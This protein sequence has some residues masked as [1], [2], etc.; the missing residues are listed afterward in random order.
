MSQFFEDKGVEELLGKGVE[1]SWINDDKIDRV[2]DDLFEF[3]LNQI[4]VEIVLS[5]IKKFAI[6]TKYY[7]WEATSFHLEGE[8]HKNKE[9]EEEIIK[10]RPIIITKGSSLY[11]RPDLK[12]CVLDLITSSDGD[13]PLFMKAGD[14]NESDK[15][16]FGRILGELTKPLDLESILVCDIAL[17]SQENLQLIQN[18]KWITRVPMTI[19]KAQLLVQTVEIEEIDEKERKRRK[20][21]NWEG[22]KWKEEIVNYGGIEQLWLV[23]ESEKRQKSDLEKL[24]KKLEKE[25]VKVEKYLKELKREELENTAQARYKLKGINKTLKL[26]K[27]EEVALIEGESKEKK[28]IN[29]IPV[30]MQEKGEEI[31]RG[32][33][34]AGRFILATNLGAENRLKPEEILPAYKNQQFGERGFIFLKYPWFFADSFFLKNSQKNWNDVVFNVSWFIGL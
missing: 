33:K 11:H 16:V 13:L 23:L 31:A 30:V 21:L 18:L 20:D 3:D 28:L 22:Y 14:G 5:V 32:K 4:F 17:Y 7:H 19:K 26:F 1:S 12:Q 15:A 8:Y 27:I 29:K 2:I 10:K 24:E 6:K 34:E 9:E 25:K